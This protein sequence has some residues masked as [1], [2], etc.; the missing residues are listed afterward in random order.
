MTPRGLPAP[1]GA[2]RSQE[3]CWINT[4]SMLKRGVG[5]SI[6]GSQRDEKKVAI[7]KMTDEWCFGHLTGINTGFKI[8]VGK[9]LLHLLLHNHF[10]LSPISNNFHERMSLWRAC[11]NSAKETV[12]APLASVMLPQIQA[13]PGASHYFTV[14]QLFSWTITFQLHM[15]KQVEDLSKAA[16]LRELF[17]NST[18]C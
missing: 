3:T 18:L 10:S 5:Q 13:Y 4:Y 14:L 7:V 1:E 9:W 16:Q 8:L 11:N 6:S 15:W 12:P 17:R 2:S